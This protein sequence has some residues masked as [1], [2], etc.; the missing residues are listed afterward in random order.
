MSGE[1][2]MPELPEPTTF[3]SRSDGRGL[4]EHIEGYTADQMR[5]YARAALEQ[6]T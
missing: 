3:L 6:K 4:I 5:D 1:N 2:G